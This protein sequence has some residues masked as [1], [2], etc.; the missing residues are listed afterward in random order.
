MRFNKIS[1]AAMLLGGGMLV[2][3]CGGGDNASSF[4]TLKGTAAKGSA[5]SGG[6]VT[7]TCKSGGKGNATSNADGSFTVTVSDGVGPCL[8]AIQPADGSPA[9]FSI[10]SGTASSQTVNIT[11]MTNLLVSYLLSVPGVTAADPTAWFALPA[12]KAL[13]IDTVEL[14]RRIVKDFIPAILKLAP[15]LSLTDTSFL[16]TAFTPNPT[17]STTDADLELLKTTSV[18]ESTGAPSAI[19]KSAVKA[20]ASDDTTVPPA[21]PAATGATGAPS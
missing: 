6:A 1:L 9:M 21:P 4:L 11:P 13:L 16:S 14:T 17:I 19:T 7:A 10:A 8:L 18:V 5:L 3:A 12:T 2:V 15:G 20:A